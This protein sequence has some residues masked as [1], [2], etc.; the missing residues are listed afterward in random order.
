M[1]WLQNTYTRSGLIMGLILR[2]L[3]LEAEESLRAITCCRPGALTNRTFIRL[4]Q[5]A[6]GSRRP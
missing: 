5:E 2:A 6:E 4:V 3:G 1:P